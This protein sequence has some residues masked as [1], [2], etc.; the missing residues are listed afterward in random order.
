M[1][2]D[3]DIG[4]DHG[5]VAQNIIQDCL[6][7]GDGEA[8]NTVAQLS[9]EGIGTFSSNTSTIHDNLLIG[10]RHGILVGDETVGSP[11]PLVFANNTI[12][13]STRSG[14]DLYHFSAFPQVHTF[15]NNIVVGS[16]LYGFRNLNPQSQMMQTNLFFNNASGDYFS[17]YSYYGY[18]WS[19]RCLG[20][21]DYRLQ[22][23]HQHG[24][25]YLLGSHI[26]H[27]RS[28]LRPGQIDLG[29]STMAGPIGLARAARGGILIE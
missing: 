26:R 13:N 11:G 9:G 3:F 23:L 27:T 1:G 17:G 20:P 2:V 7:I 18:Y 25:R 12:V 15:V 22:R 24:S 10:N 16:E 6:G 19:D 14:I 4:N 21:A 29:V 28:S 8:S 5:E